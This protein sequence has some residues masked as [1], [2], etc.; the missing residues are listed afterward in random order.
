MANHLLKVIL[1]SGYERYGHSLSLCRANLIVQ[2]YSI[3]RKVLRRSLEL[4]I[5]FLLPLIP[6]AFFIILFISLSYII[7][8]PW[9][10]GVLGF[11]GFGVL[12]GGV[13]SHHVFQGCIKLSI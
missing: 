6:L 7:L 2:T 3:S 1:Y 8:K 4:L 5:S 11:W 10:F 9:G 13:K 12:G